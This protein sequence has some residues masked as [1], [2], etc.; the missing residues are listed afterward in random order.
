M[1]QKSMSQNDREIVQK[2]KVRIGVVAKGMLDGSIDYI[3]GAVELESLR[4]KIDA[5]NND[6]DFLAFIT[7]AS[8]V[9]LDSLEGNETEIQKT[10]AWAKDFSLIQCESLAQRFK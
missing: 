1:S 8:E 9:D 3:E 5:Y 4:H 10:I 6:L 7:I 2:N